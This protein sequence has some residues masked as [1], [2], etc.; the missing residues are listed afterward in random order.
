MGDHPAMSTIIAAKYGGPCLRCGSQIKAGS[1]VN[2]KR[3]DG[4]WHLEDSYCSDTN[5]RG[6]KVMSS[7][8]D[9]TK[10]GTININDLLKALQEINKKN[11]PVEITDD[12]QLK[13]VEPPKEKEKQ[14]S[15]RDKKIQISIRNKKIGGH[16]NLWRH[17]LTPKQLSFCEFMALGSD[18][19]DAYTNSYDITNSAYSNNA[20]RKLLE[21]KK[22]RDKIAELRNELGDAGTENGKQDFFDAIRSEGGKKGWAFKLTENQERFCRSVANGATLLNAFKKSGYSILN[23]SEKRMRRTANELMKKPKIRIRITDLMSGNAP[24]LETGKKISRSSAGWYKETS[25][26]F[27]DALNANK[28]VVPPPTPDLKTLDPLGLPVGRSRGWHEEKHTNAAANGEFV[29]NFVELIKAHGRLFHHAVVTRGQKEV[30]I[31][32][33]DVKGVE[34]AVCRSIETLKETLSKKLSR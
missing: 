3:G 20:A 28:S 26:E 31:P 8:N 21:N 10:G 12:V 15:V 9:E 1:F 27:A 13:V 23:F 5:Q 11:T 25:D 24:D 14:P 4:I 29:D 34:E 18:R 16:A 22:I 30:G 6:G 33:A 17:K 32:G 7:N 19:A 2:W